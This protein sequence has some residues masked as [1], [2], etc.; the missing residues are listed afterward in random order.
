MKIHTTFM[1]HVVLTVS[2]ITK[3]REWWSKVTGSHATT[4]HEG[5]VS[6]LVGPQAI[7]LRQG[8]PAPPGTVSICLL[9]DASIHELYE[10]AEEL[11]AVHGEVHPRTAA[12]AP[13]QA[14]TLE[15]PDG[16]RVE[17]ATEIPEGVAT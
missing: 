3:S 6:L 9:A 14:L 10:R 13:A 16:Y 17:L 1:D 5:E 8:T 11:H 7:R 12:T 4:D 2:D 15:D